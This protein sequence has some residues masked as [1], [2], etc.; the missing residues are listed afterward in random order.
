MSYL[1]ALEVCSL[2][3]TRR[4][5]NPRLPLPLPLPLYFFDSASCNQSVC[6][7]WREY[8]YRWP[9]Y[10]YF[11]TSPIRL[12]N[13]YSLP[14]WVRPPKRSQILSRPPKGTS[15]A[16][17]MR[18]GVWIVPIG[19]E[20][21][22]GRVTKKKQKSEKK[23][24]WQVAYLPRPPTKRYPHHSCHVGLSP[25]RSQPWQVSLKSVQGFWSL[26]S[27]NLPFSYA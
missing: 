7:I 25:G 24:D 4:Y 12:R 9:I 6:E 27:R 23:R 15:L 18:F 3:T 26:G 14:F 17:N 19:Q 10:G 1:S 22:P 13:V 21:R 20:M 2:F 11:T 8:L 16:G 5:T